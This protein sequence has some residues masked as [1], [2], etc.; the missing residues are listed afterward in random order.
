MA[1][2]AA[3]VVVS[4]PYTGAKKCRLS[5]LDSLALAESESAC[6]WAGG[7]SGSGGSDGVTQA[8][9]GRGTGT[10]TLQMSSSTSGSDTPPS[11]SL[12]RQLR[13]GRDS[14]PALLVIVTAGSP[15]PRLG[16]LC[17]VAIL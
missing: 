4:C 16:G 15:G 7:G 9:T 6:Q 5:G 12:S 3:W 10:G 8:T 2:L 17:P 1:E 14:S 13:V 11:Q